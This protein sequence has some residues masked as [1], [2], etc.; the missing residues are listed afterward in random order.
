[1]CHYSLDSQLA[2]MERRFGVKTRWRPTDREYLDT[3]RSSLTEKF[4]QLHTRLGISSQATLFA[5]DESKI[6]RYFI[7]SYLYCSND[8]DIIFRWA[9]DSQETLYKH[10][11][12]S[13]TN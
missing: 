13:E 2:D 10:H 7:I 1:M 9:E 6:C 11:K 8:V 12:G 5:K 3:R 4:S